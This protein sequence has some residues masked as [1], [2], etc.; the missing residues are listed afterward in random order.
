MAILTYPKSAAEVVATLV[1]LLEHQGQLALADML[2]AAQAR[3]EH[4][5]SDNWNGGTDYFT[6]FLELPVRH[7]APIEPTLE[8]VEE[9]IGAKLTRIFRAGSGRVLR[10]VEITAT[11]SEIRTLSRSPTASSS[12]VTHIWDAGFLRLFLSHVSAHKV[13]AA[14]LK[15]ELGFLG[16]SVFVAHEDIK[17]SLEWEQEIEKALA[18]MDALAALLTDDFHASHWTDQEI[19]VAL[20]RG[21]PVIPMKLHVL[22]YGFVG[23]F[24]AIDG[25]LEAV[26]ELASRVVDALLRRPETADKMRG[27][28]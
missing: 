18:S 3:I 16:V 28:A 23:K 1:E 11:A 2:R 15:R 7:F 17:P 22:P 13:A 21:I 5:E 6:L 25:R 12:E 4:T 26:D 14:G 19:G 24:Q 8:R 9:A 10:R 20:G 27:E